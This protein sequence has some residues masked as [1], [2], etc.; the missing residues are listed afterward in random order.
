MSEDVERTALGSS[1]LTE[2]ELQ[3][4]RA[5]LTQADAEDTFFASLQGFIVSGRTP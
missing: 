3:R 4:W 1:M 5:A 2:D